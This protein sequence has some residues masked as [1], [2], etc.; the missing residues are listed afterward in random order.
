MAD[1]S[2]AGD[3]QPMKTHGV[4]L[5]VLV[6]AGCGADDGPPTSDPSAVRPILDDAHEYALIG[7]PAWELA[8]A[9]DYRPGQP[10]STVGTITPPI[11][12]YAEYDH[13][14]VELGGGVISVDHL[15]LTGLE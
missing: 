7:D 1:R 11:D 9:V 3:G 4:L 10:F 13:E 2:A 14:P 6:L 5:A 12:W 8:E 15:V